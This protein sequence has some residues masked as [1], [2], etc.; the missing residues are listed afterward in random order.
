M[1]N[2]LTSAS[3]LLKIKRHQ[4]EMVRD[5]GYD[6]TQEL[7]LL[8]ISDNAF[9]QY[10]G[11]AANQHRVSLRSLLSQVYQKPETEDKLLVFYAEMPTK[12]QVGI[13]TISPHQN[14][15]HRLPFAPHQPPP[16]FN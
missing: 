13:D 11:D 8:G 9:F 16:L 15:A 14:G 10:Y 12:K 6:V 1:S 3:R 7:N 2:N 5:R 4:I